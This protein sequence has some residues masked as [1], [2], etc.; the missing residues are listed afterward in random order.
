L[1]LT[2]LLILA[3]A[4]LSGYSCDVDRS[5]PPEESSVA[6]VGRTFGEPKLAAKLADA[7]VDESSGVARSYEHAGSYYTHND[8]GDT[9]RF[10]RFDLKGAVQGPYKVEGG[11]VDWEDMASAKLGGKSYLYFADFGDNAEKRASVQIYRVEEPKGAPSSAPLK[12]EVFELT[13]PDGPHNAEAFLV[14]PLTGEFNIVTKTTKETSLIFVLKSPKPGPARLT[15]AGEWK[16]GEAAEPARLVTGGDFSADGRYVVIRTYIA[17]YEFELP[18]SGE[19]WKTEAVKIKL[20]AELQG[21]AI[22]YSLE[23][24]RL[25]TTSEFSPCP[26]STVA[27]TP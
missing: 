11:A 18:F 2:P 9:A 8:S 19:W 7:A 23:G 17:A 5:A 12:A 10:W 16:S 13:Y 22:A 25:V 24:D 3:T 26:V 14:N 6:T 21:E 15:K 27:I 20:A 4:L 1:K